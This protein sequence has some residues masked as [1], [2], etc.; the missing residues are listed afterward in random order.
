VN[1][2]CG[3]SPFCGQLPSTLLLASLTVVAKLKHKYASR[4]YLRLES[5]GI[6]SRDKNK[7]ASP[8]GHY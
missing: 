6:S 3:M 2:D 5:I 8:F 7:K 4:L 1:G